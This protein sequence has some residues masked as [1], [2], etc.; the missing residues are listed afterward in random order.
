MVLPAAAQAAPFMNGG[1]E[2][3]SVDPG[4]GFVTLGSNSTAITGWVVTGSGIDYI[5]GYW[6]PAEGN[7]SIDLNGNGSGGIQ[8]TFTTVTGRL[9]TV[10]FSLAGNPDGGPTSKVMST[11]ANGNGSE[12]FTFDTTGRS[13]TNM[14]WTEYTYD[15]IAGGP[16]TTLTFTS[17]IGGA[18]GA[19]LDLVSVNGSVPEPATWAL[20]I[21]GMG[22]VGGAMRRR[23]KAA[24][25]FA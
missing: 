19:A 4:S 21:L 10:T 1:F 15:F 6:Q 22:A 18:Y 9:Y 25:R 20:M 12:S 24:V 2:S 7:R 14:G 17:S 11:V 23:T 16:T 3:A 5:G 13:R 8:Q